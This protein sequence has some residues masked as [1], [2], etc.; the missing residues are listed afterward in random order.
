[1]YNCQNSPYVK[2]ARDLLKLA[3]Q[4][5]VTTYSPLTNKDI[6]EIN[7]ALINYSK[8]CN[9]CQKGGNYYD[10]FKEAEQ[11]LIRAMPFMRKNIYP[12]KNYDWD[13]S[14]FIDNNYSVL[15]T[16]ASKDGTFTAMFDNIKAFTELTNG[17]LFSPNPDSQSVSG[18][19]NIKDDIN[20]YACQG[21]TIDSNG[22]ITINPALKEACLS[23]HKVKY[24]NQLPPPTNDE[25]LKKYP[26][27]GKNSSSYYVKIGNCPRSKIT[28]QK[29]CE[30]MGYNWIPN[31]LNS[32]INGLS[33]SC[34]QPRYAYINNR[35]G[36]TFGGVNLEGLIPSLEQD[37]M[38]LSPDKI[39]AAFQG[40]NI[41][42]LL[43]IQPCPKE[44]FINYKSSYFKH[45]KIYIIMFLV[46]IIYLLY[47]II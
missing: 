12:W 16:G 4:G 14:N 21:K 5:G 11:K 37:I 25:F 35:P 22:N 40:E 28:N 43:E 1:M 47:N 32:V 42:N 27:D 39:L 15:T 18:G 19:N 17:Y 46:I 10:C 23:K 34:Y 41:E 45:Y 3:K 2:I 6:E 13:Y 20:W 31:S 7:Q 24:S 9:I 29:K 44:G 26:T 33:G 30:D 8:D 38:A 36:Y